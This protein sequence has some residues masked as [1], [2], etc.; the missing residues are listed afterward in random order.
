M[1]GFDLFLDE[2]LLHDT[3]I[4]SCFKNLCFSNLD[5]EDLKAYSFYGFVILINSALRQP[6]KHFC[7]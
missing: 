5:K 4:A 7:E 3:V 2:Q 6:K 1:V